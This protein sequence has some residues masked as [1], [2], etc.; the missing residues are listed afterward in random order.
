[1]I[2]LYKYGVKKHVY[3]WLTSFIVVFKCH[4]GCSHV[5]VSSEWHEV[6]FELEMRSVHLNIKI[7]DALTNID[8]SVYWL[9]NLQNS[10][11]DLIQGLTSKSEIFKY[12]NRNSMNLFE[13][14]VKN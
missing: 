13:N 8:Y 11:N 7:Y 14:S 10:V 9:K 2:Q 3:V 5:F 1:M 6:M 4:R 12:W